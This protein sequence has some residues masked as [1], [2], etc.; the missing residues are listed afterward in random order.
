[1]ATRENQTIVESAVEARGGVTGH[2]ARYVLL[3]STAMVVVLFTAIYLF[4]FA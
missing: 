2:K 1:M 4:N 3:I